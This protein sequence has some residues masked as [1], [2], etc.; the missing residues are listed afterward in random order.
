MNYHNLCTYIQFDQNCQLSNLNFINILHYSINPVVQV[1]F[2]ITSGFSLTTCSL[3]RCKDFAAMF[4]LVNIKFAWMQGH[5][6]SC[7]KL[8]LARLCIYITTIC[9]KLIKINSWL[10]TIQVMHYVSILLFSIHVF[11][12]TN[13]ISILN[14][15]QYFL[16]Q[17]HTTTWN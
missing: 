4:S 7:P 9:L 15:K 11:F 10:V 5:S 13:F 17:R 2:C 1:E 8:M 12:S 3:N 6:V 14:R 16:Q